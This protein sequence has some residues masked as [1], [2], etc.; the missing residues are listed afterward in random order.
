MGFFKDMRSV[1]QTANA[2]TPPEHRGLTGTMRMAKDGM[3]QMNDALTG[4]AAEAQKAQHLMAAG[5]VGTA[6]VS[7][8]RDTGT[9]INDNPVV[10]LDLQVTVDGGVPYAVTHRQTISRLAVAGFQPG[11]TVPVRVDPM[12]PHSLIV[13]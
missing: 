12:D 13:A 2:M 1:M 7:A 3:A 9:T 6:T 10:D 5:R 11:S 4:M 8:L